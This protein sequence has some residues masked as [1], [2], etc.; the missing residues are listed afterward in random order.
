M[1]F[2]GLWNF[3]EGLRTQGDALGWDVSAFQAA[4]NLEGPGIRRGPE[5]PGRCPG[6]GCVS[7]SGCPDFGGSLEFGEGL[8]AQGDALR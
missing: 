7:L 2:G 6:V 4:R 3:G 1:K 8:R 5:N